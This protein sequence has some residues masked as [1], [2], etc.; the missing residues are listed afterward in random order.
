MIQGCDHSNSTIKPEALTAHGIQFVCR[1]I[2]PGFTG[3]QLE[4]TELHALH[5]AGISVVANYETQADRALHGA[6]AGQQDATDAAHYM[7]TFGFPADRPVY[8]SVDFDVQDHYLDTIHDYFRGIATVLKPW[9]VGIYGGKRVVDFMATSG[10]CNWLWQTYAWSGG[11]WHDGTDIE[12]YSN[13]HAVDGGTVDL[14][15]A[16]DGDF[17]GWLPMTPVDLS[18]AALTALDH[19]V[20]HN[21]T[22]ADPINPANPHLSAAQT[23]YVTGLNVLNTLKGVNAAL[24]DL[25]DIQGRLSGMSL[26]PIALAAALAANPAFITAMSSAIAEKLTTLPTADEIGKSV[27]AAYLRQ[28]T[29]GGNGVV[30]P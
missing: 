6:L 29:S 19:P 8:F 27:F 5:Q 1:Y 14:D 10:L 4:S 23:L 13:G 9:Q 20:W 15:R 28:L 30:A 16:I 11:L 3:K 26:D 24:V 12:Q 18:Q 22:V 2:N 21:P 17:G 25:A 7:S